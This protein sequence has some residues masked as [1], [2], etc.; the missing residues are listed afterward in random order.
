MQMRRLMLIASLAT[1]AK[2]LDQ[3]MSGEAEECR[4]SERGRGVSIFSPRLW[5]STG[6]WSMQSEIRETCATVTSSRNRSRWEC[7]WTTNQSLAAVADMVWLY[8]GMY[9]R[10]EHQASL[11]PKAAGQQ[12]AVFE[13]EPK[14]KH[15]L[16]WS[17]AKIGRGHLFDFEVSWK[18]SA[19]VPSL[20]CSYADWK[21]LYRPPPHEWSTEALVSAFISNAAASWERTRFL[22]ELMDL[23]PVKSFGRVLN[24]AISPPGTE[25]KV[26]SMRQ[27][28][29]A[30]VLENEVDNDYVSEKIYEA[31][32]AGVLPIYKG[33]PNVHKFLPCSHCVLLLDNFNSVQHLAQELRRLDQD[34]AAFM[35]YFRWKKES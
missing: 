12:F 23:V 34:G 29:F 18:L 33:A 11:P 1:M 30:L 10:E 6:A 32:M 14:H 17:W 20:Y 9:N 35:E 31:M 5:R 22:R 26:K 27:Y 28:K 2:C 25:G 16:F 19:H 3:D 8:A 15:S 7:T 21:D 24:N 4:A 13:G